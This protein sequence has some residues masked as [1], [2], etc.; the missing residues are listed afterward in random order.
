MNPTAL[1]TGASRGIGKGIATL[2]AQH[3]F[4]I[5]A[6]ARDPEKLK[7]LKSDIEEKYQVKCDIF[8]LDISDLKAQ[9]VWFTNNLNTLSQINLL[10][11]NAGIAPEK[12]TDLLDTTPESYD[13]IMNTN[14]KG[15]FFLTQKIASLMIKNT[16]QTNSP[17]FSKRIIFV[18]SISAVTASINRGEYCISKA[19]LSMTAKLY[20]TKLAEFQIPVF[21]IRPGIIST[22]MTASVKEKYDDLIFNKN[23]LLQKRWGTP[24]DVAKCVLAIA[25]GYFDYATGNIF[26]INGGFSISRL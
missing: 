22:D 11:N 13:K 19:G 10:V 24:I 6:V 20:A 1:I 4:D 16:N 7:Y 2:L 12:R 15:P 21:E 8:T 23:L 25:E 18:T 9:E 5:I 17:R 26:E 14:L 3:G